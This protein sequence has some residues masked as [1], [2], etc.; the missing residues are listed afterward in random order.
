M[1]LRLAAAN[2]GY[3]L[4][5]GMESRDHDSAEAIAGQN[6]RITSTVLKQEIAITKFSATNNKSHGE[7]VSTFKKSKKNLAPFHKKYNVCI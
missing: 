5:N 2:G 4:R 1:L 6:K 3:E 7:T